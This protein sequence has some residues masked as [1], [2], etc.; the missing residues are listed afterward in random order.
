VGLGAA[1]TVVILVLLL[2]ITLA[3]L[4]FLDRRVHYEQ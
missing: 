2:A 3:K 4:R 1:G